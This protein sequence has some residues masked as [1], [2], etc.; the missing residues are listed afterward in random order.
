MMRG[1]RKI[2]KRIS[3]KRLQTQLFL[4]VP[5]A[6]IACRSRCSTAASVSDRPKIPGFHRVSSPWWLLGN[7]CA[8][9]A[10]WLQHH[11]TALTMVSVCGMVTCVTF[12]GSFSWRQTWR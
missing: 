6:A 3:T 12:R 10:A 4:L 11:N 2:E 1:V 7:A 5:A 8:L 9:G